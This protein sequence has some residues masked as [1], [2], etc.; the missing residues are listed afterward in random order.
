MIKYVLIFL[1]PVAVWAAYPT[2]EGLFRYGADIDYTDDLVLLDLVIST[3]KNPKLF[4]QNISSDFQSEQLTNG[5]SRRDRLQY[6]Q[7]LFAKKENRTELL[8]VH[9][10]RG[11]FEEKDANHSRYFPSLN[12]TLRDD[13]LTVRTLFYSLMSM[14]ALNTSEHMVNL[15]RRSVPNFKT[16]RDLMSEEK[17]ELL[18]RYRRYLERTREMEGMD[19]E[20]RE[21]L[22]SPLRPEDPEDL[23]L[24]RE[25]M[26]GPMYEKDKR[27][28][29]KKEGRRFYWNLDY[30]NFYARFSNDDQYLK[31]LT[32]HM[33]ESPIRVRVSHY[34]TFDGNKVLPR[35]ILYETPGGE[36]FKISIANFRRVRNRGDRLSQMARDYAQR[37]EQRVSRG[38]IKRRSD[39]L[40]QDSL[41]LDFLY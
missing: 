31:S 7:L 35:Q 29:L 38:E 3:E 12:N 39:Y 20:D 4:G 11:G 6:V 21:E 41:E 18:R 5:P 26:S 34:V 36:L 9:F 17:R 14:Y 37:V 23:E 16:N 24:V 19:E 40:E 2:P 22:V 13:T 8:Q 15:L 1:L 10:D 33:T 30:E 25:I 28:S 27:L 32:L